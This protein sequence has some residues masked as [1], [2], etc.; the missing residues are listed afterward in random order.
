MLYCSSYTTYMTRGKCGSILQA[1]NY[2]LYYGIWVKCA[3]LSESK[4]LHS[5]PLI[6]FILEYVLKFTF[7]Y[8][9]VNGFLCQLTGRW[10]SKTILYQKL[11]TIL[12]HLSKVRSTVRN[13]LHAQFTSDWLQMWICSHVYPCL[14]VC[15]SIFMS[16]D[17]KMVK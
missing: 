6:D 8:D 7:V 15:K 10:L 1:Q 9:C 3:K 12:C 11:Y 17:R 5:L 2:I 13:Q 14:W 4:Y 16:V